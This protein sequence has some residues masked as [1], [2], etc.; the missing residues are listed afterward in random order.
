[1]THM[2]C[3]WLTWI[4]SIVKHVWEA[5][6]SSWASQESEGELLGT[7]QG[8]NVKRPQTC[9]GCQWLTWIDNGSRALRMAHAD[10]IQ[11]AQE[12]HKQSSRYIDIR[13]HSNWYSFSFID[14]H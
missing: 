9:L 12:M 6:Q 14:I 11:C 13:W 5:V 3:Q 7:L 8:T 4:E 10:R 2:D 1:M